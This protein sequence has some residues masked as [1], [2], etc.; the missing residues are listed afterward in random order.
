MQPTTLV[1]FGDSWP[2]GMELRNPH[3]DA[4]PYLV[5]DKMGFSNIINLSQCGASLQ[6]YFLQLK[7]FVSIKDL[8]PSNTKYSFL[9]CMTSCVRDLYFN[10]FGEPREIVPTDRSKN[11]YYAD[12]FHWPETA[13]LHWYRTVMMFQNYCLSNYINDYYVQM[14]D[15][16]PFDSEYNKFVD[17][18]VIYKNATTHMNDLLYSRS[19]SRGYELSHGPFVNRE[20]NEYQEYFAPNES[21]PNPAGHMRIAHEITSWV[22]TVRTR[23][24][25]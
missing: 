1:V 11:S 18:S 7:K 24:N 5:K 20:S 19:G 9:V 22:P 16:P 15:T 3:T 6:H 21:H 25:R 17:F 4:F 12:H 8:Y 2:A 10:E 14:F 23:I 13:K